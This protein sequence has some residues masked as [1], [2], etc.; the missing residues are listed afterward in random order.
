MSL[1]QRLEDGRSVGE[2]VLRGSGLLCREGLVAL[3]R[4][5]PLVGEAGT[6][7]AQANHSWL[8]SGF[9]YLSG[10]G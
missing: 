1:C 5:S 6:L 3:R 4:L 9:V 2:L 8:R 7:T 10:P